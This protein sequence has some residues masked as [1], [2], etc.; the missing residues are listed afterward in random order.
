MLSLLY[1]I[2]IMMMMHYESGTRFLF[3]HY[4]IMISQILKHDFALPGAVVAQA[5]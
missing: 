5:V 4:E 3:F 1:L 2:I